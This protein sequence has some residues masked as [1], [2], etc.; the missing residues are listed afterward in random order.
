MTIIDCTGKQTREIN[1]EIRS[2]IAAGETE[3]HLR[4]P[5]ARHN[6]AVGIRRR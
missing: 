1:R 5:G 6:L 3:I 4:H 2:L